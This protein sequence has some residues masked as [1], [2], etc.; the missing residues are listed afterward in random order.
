M[1]GCQ[2]CRVGRSPI[3]CRSRAL[4]LG[5]LA[6]L[7]ILSAAN[8]P[9]ADPP[10]PALPFARKYTVYYS[11]TSAK[12]DPTLVVRTASFESLIKAQR[13]TEDERTW[14]KLIGGGIHQGSTAVTVGSAAGR[15]VRFAY[16]PG[17]RVTLRVGDQSLEIGLSAAQARPMAFLVAEGN[18]SLVTLSERASHRG[19]YGFRPKLAAPYI[20]TEEGY[21]LLW[22]DAICEDLFFS[23]DFGWGT[24]PN[25]LTM[26]D[27]AR[28]VTI[29]TE[30]TLSV[31]GGEPRVAFWK[32]AA[33]KSG[34]IVRYEELGRVLEPR[35]EEDT[36]AIDAVN[37]LFKWAPVMRLAAGS[38]PAAFQSF[39]HQLE[40][41]HIAGVATPRL[42]I[43]E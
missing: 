11:G 5:A 38:D 17:D 30:R 23:V 37:R 29:R 26:V 4:V 12:G 41:V 27:S 43:E 9:L 33:G 6:A 21:W 10:K 16:G 24:F 42:M 13:A 32:T 39:L 2:N 28:P 15:P 1:I 7:S 35:C 19:K 25:G 20:D 18:N 3:N 36:R 40:Q 8:S 34:T 31:Q 14:A 22:A